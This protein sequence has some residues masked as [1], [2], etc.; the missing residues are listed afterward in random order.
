MSYS[1]DLAFREVK[2]GEDSL[3]IIQQIKNRIIENID[4]LIKDNITYSPY[5]RDSLEWEDLDVREL[6]SKTIDW[7][8]RMLMYKFIYFPERH[9]IACV[10]TKEPFLEDLFENFT[11]F[12]NSCD[13][14]YNYD[15]WKGI[16]QFEEVVDKVQPIPY[17]EEGKQQLIELLR[18]HH[19]Y[20]NSSDLEECCKN[21]ESFE[22][23][24][25]SAVYSIIF[26]PLEEVVFG[27]D[28]LTMWIRCAP[29]RYDLSCKVALTKQL[30]KEWAAQWT[31]W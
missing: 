8:E 21:L 15:T 24:K 12:Q 29:S 9:L 16:K 25:R 1:I 20:W 5:I 18:S 26:D 14:D 6:S 30:A 27:T 28:Q 19:P 3:F 10:T 4:Y 17:T 23:W 31:K 13:Q 11:F 7:L 22:Y 2:E